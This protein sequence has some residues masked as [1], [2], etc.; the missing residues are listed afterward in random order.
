MVLVLEM[1]CICKFVIKKIISIKGYCPQAWILFI[2]SRSPPIH[3]VVESPLFQYCTQAGADRHFFLEQKT[4]CNFL[5]HTYASEA[6][7]LFA[8]IVWPY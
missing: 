8:P 7:Y 6:R 1:S 3:G 5:E 2:P 4:L